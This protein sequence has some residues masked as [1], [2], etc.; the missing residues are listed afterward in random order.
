MHPANSLD[1]HEQMKYQILEAAMAPKFS[2]YNIYVGRDIDLGDLRNIAAANEILA[3]FE[4]IFMDGAVVHGVDVSGVNTSARLKKL[5]GYILLLVADY[6]TYQNK[7]T[8]VAVDLPI[9]ITDK[10]TDVE[11]GEEIASKIDGQRVTVIL[12]DRRARLFYSGPGWK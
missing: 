1:P 9:K 8:E 2:G 12:S 3:R 10:L 5:G 7:E 6:S 4:D 11:T